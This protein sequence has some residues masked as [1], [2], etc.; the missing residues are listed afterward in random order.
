MPEFADA[1]VQV[2]VV[3]AQPV[4]AKAAGVPPVQFAVSV[5]LVLTCG[6]GLLAANAQANAVA[7]FQVTTIA[8]DTLLN[9][10][11]DAPTEYVTVPGTPAV[12]VHVL[13]VPVQPLHVYRVGAPVHVAL[14]VI[15][16]PTTGLRLLAESV[17]AMGPADGAGVAPD[18]CHTTLAIAGRLVAVC[19]DAVTTYA[20]A[21]VE[22]DVAVQVL[23][24]PLV[25]PVHW[26]ETGFPEQFAVS[27]IAVPITG[28]RSDAAAVQVMFSSA[29]GTQNAVGNT[30]GP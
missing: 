22:L 9:V 20:R 12:A 3:L 24:P 17:H 15:L 26:Y 11:F 30:D 10:P 8:V 27:V 21:P 29:L 6:D 25:H 4:H 18:G 16:S 1:V 5:T 14:S 23:P 19:V 13:P 2:L 28:C 7:A